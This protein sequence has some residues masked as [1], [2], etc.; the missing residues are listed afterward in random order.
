MKQTP[1]YEAHKPSK[2]LTGIALFTILVAVLLV[3]FG[4]MTYL[5]NQQT[6]SKL[7]EQVAETNRLAQE[8]KVIANQNKENSQRAANYAYCNAYL[9]AK[10]TQDGLP[11]L[12]EDLNKCVVTVF[13][14]G[15]GA[16]TIPTEGFQ[17][18]QGNVQGS[19]S[20]SATGSSA[21]GTTSPQGTSSTPQGTSQPS[22]QQQSQSAL[23]VQPSTILPSLTIVPDVKIPG[24]L[25]IR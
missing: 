12:I 16:P 23:E 3:V 20:S 11:I 17:A 8:L 4:A 13:P 15:E 6:K 2:F 25:E 19:S 18:A 9:F 24:I 22:T 14:N 10:Y 7:D 21:Q 1:V 5:Q